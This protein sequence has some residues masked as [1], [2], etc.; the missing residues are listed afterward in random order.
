MCKEKERN[1]GVLSTN[2][3]VSPVIVLYIYIYERHLVPLPLYRGSLP[4]Q[5]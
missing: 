1:F 3:N 4:H 2:M 5:I